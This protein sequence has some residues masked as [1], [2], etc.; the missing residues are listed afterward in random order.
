MAGGVRRHDFSALNI[1]TDSDGWTF[2]TFETHDLLVICSHTTYTL[3][4]PSALS[5]HRNTCDIV[6]LFFDRSQ[7]RS[8]SSTTQRYT[9]PVSP[10][11]SLPV[12]TGEHGGAAEFSQAQPR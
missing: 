4:H 2:S 7:T 8:L 6:E 3:C 10:L 9:A 5:S 1:S 12:T 11:A